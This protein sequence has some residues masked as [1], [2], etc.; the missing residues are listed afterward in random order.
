[1]DIHAYRNHISLLEDQ[2]V[3]RRTETFASAKFLH[4]EMDIFWYT[5]RVKQMQDVADNVILQ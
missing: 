3:P 4:S 1:M 5:S 2:T